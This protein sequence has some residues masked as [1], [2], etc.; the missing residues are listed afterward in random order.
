LS[1]SVRPMPARDA[2]SDPRPPGRGTTIAAE[3]VGEAWLDVARL[4]LDHGADSHWEGLPLLEVELVTLEVSRPDPD[5]EL[6]ARHASAEWLAWMR[7]N[8]IER[9]RVAALGDAR[10]YA[11]RLFDYAGTGPRPAR[12]GGR[13]APPRPGHQQRHHHHLRAADRHHLHSLRQP[14]RFLAA[15]R[16]GWSSLPMPTASILARRASAIWS[17]WPSCSATSRASSA[18]PRAR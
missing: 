1:A 17:S 11:S 2:P 10:S 12:L 14:A 4:I 6:I 3:T 18:C 5:D 7:A 9:T 16:G 8:F 13:H 15:G